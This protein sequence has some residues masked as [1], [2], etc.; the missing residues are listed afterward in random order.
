VIKK[1]TT[2][3][4]TTS[5]AIEVQVGILEG[6]SRFSVLEKEKLL[7]LKLQLEELGDFWVDIDRVRISFIAKNIQYFENRIDDIMRALNEFE[8]VK[9]LVY[10]KFL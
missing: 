10:T 1:I 3:D 4:I 9:P 6:M 8:N 5:G 2:F 7:E